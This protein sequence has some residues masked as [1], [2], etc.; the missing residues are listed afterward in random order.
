MGR[1]ACVSLSLAVV[2]SMFLCGRVWG[3]AGGVAEF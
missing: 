2:R 1:V 3:F